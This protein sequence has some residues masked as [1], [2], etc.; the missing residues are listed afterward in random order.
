MRVSS[1]SNQ[2]QGKGEVPL[3]EKR[4]VLHEVRVERDRGAAVQLQQPLRHRL[5]ELRDRMELWQ[6]DGVLGAQADAP[7][8]LDPEGAMATESWRNEQRDHEVQAVGEEAEPV[9]RVEAPVHA[10]EDA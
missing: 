10:G 8:V 4:Y 7:D 3:D 9:C 5:A 2:R 6:R 1:S